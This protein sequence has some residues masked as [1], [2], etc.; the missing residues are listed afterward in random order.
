MKNTQIYHFENSTPHNW[1]C[2]SYERL[3]TLTTTQIEKSL[4]F[5]F[6]S[7]RK[8][9]RN[10]NFYCVSWKLLVDLLLL[11]LLLLIVGITLARSLSFSLI[12]SFHDKWDL[13]QH[14]NVCLLQWFFMT[15]TTTMIIFCIL[16]H[17]FCYYVM[18]FHSSPSQSPTDLY[19]NLLLLRELIECHTQFCVTHGICNPWL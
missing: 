1:Q 6:V 14:T 13:M 10:F 12:S 7:E 17:D 16:K 5:F 2:V 8:R 19:S 15:M 18:I 9:M 3:H 11:I 4:E